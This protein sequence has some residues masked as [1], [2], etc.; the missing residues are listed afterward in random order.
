MTGQAPYAKL[1]EKGGSMSETLLFP[2]RDLIGR[3]WTCPKNAPRILTAQDEARASG[4]LNCDSYA[5]DAKT[6]Y[7][8]DVPCPDCHGI[9]RFYFETDRHITPE[10]LR[11]E[12][13][14]EIE[15]VFH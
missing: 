9:H 14:Q 10:Q 5:K 12:Q 8:W 1:L 3:P 13:D 7:R 4:D 11:T 2:F 6:R 15:K